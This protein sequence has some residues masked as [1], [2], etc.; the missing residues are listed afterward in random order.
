MFIRL[1]TLLIAGL[2]T[3]L[4]SLACGDDDE[5]TGPDTGASLI[6]SITPTSG[7]VGDTVTIYG[8]DFETTAGPLSLRIGYGSISPIFSSDSLLRFRVPGGATTARPVLTHGSANS[9]A[10]EVF[11]VRWQHVSPG[12]ST[13]HIND[14]VRF[15]DYF[16]IVGDDGLAMA[17]S[18]GAWADRSRGT[19]THYAAVAF[20]DRVVASYGVSQVRTFQP[21]GLVDTVID[22]STSSIGGYL[23]AASADAAVAVPRQGGFVLTSADGLA[24]QK[25]DLPDTVAPAVFVHTD[26]FVIYSG[27][28]EIWVSTDGLNWSGEFCNLTAPALRA[29]CWTGQLLM[30]V[31]PSAVMYSYDSQNF[32]EATPRDFPNADFLGVS[33]TGDIFLVHTDDGLIW[34]TGGPQWARHA[35]F[36]AVPTT[37][38]KI[39]CDDRVCIAAG[40]FG[41]GYMI[42][43]LT[44]GQPQ[45]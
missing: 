38:P 17:G 22:F 16:V 36:P 42:W 29:A 13:R 25:V 43:W 40:G 39:A 19:T 2:M 15:A 31:K 21:E 41:N 6:D 27:G 23:L 28:P 44:T 34:S 18:A 7:K 5:P 11:T 14:I 30:I 3:V 20:G 8:R 24:W 45:P 10:R 4:L 1:R 37:V 32:S 33:W 26:R 9:A 12:P 35:E